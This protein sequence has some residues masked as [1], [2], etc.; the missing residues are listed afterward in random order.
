M[1]MYLQRA[2][3]AWLVLLAS[4]LASCQSGSQLENHSQGQGS[5]SFSPDTVAPEFPAGFTEELR[6]TS[7][8][9][10]YILNGDEALENTADAV[11]N[12]DSLEMTAASGD[13]SWALYRFDGML[14]WYTLNELEV[15]FDALPSQLYAAVAD[16]ESGRWIWQTLG[17]AHGGSGVMQAMPWPAT[18]NYITP[19][20]SVYVVILLHDGTAASLQELRIR[21]DD[22]E[23]GPDVT[24][25]ASPDRG[26]GPLDVTFSANASDRNG[27][28][29]STYEWDWEGDGI[30]DTT[31]STDNEMH[32]YPSQGEYFPIVRVTDDDDGLSETDQ[33]RIVVRGWA[34]SLGGADYDVNFGVA[35]SEKHRYALGNYSKAALDA[36]ALIAKYDSNGNLLWQRSWGGG[37]SDTF[38]DAVE[39]ANGDVIVLGETESDLSTAAIVLMR[40][41]RD[42]NL[43]WGKTWDSAGHDYGAQIG[44]D[45]LGNIWVL[46]VVFSPDFSLTTS[47]VILKYDQDGT[48]L[49][50]KGIKNDDRVFLR[51]LEV[52]SSNRVLLG[53]EC[54]AYAVKKDQLLVMELAGDMSIT[55][56]RVL[57][58]NFDSKLFGMELDPASGDILVGGT[59]VDSGMSQ[60]FFASLG[61]NGSWQWLT[62]AKNAGQNVIR[63]MALQYY[64]GL[65]GGIVGCGYTFETPR[66]GVVY[67]LDLNGG[68][69]SSYFLRLYGCRTAGSDQHSVRVD[70]VHR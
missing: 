24:L 32:T 57:D 40:L 55:S 59:Y 16:F 53:G 14:D 3:L 19:Q 15:H 2:G 23:N 35:S 37:S 60:S 13:I 42:G 45:E 66:K 31:G 43:L 41:D 49:G 6:N 20:G 30:F 17:T 48:Y 64:N 52:V 69:T 8:L 21:Y 51:C 5:G 4:L 47:S 18:G 70:A 67:S 50:S 22:E 36:D 34:H 11:P 68:D 61:S 54:G 63:G 33:I 58:W 46:G 62:S 7:I 28:L 25:G 39:T 38:D 56:E 12:A 29:I 9:V 44:M 27:G 26:A 10:E 1:Y 65:A